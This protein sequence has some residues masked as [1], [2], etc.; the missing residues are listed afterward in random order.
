MS[1]AVILVIVIGVSV[2]SL[3]AAFVLRDCRLNKRRQSERRRKHAD[4]LA[5]GRARL[6]EPQMNRK[7]IV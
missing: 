7:E 5:Q 3:L 4:E 1:T 2:G 6:G